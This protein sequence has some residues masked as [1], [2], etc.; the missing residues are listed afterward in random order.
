MEE[1]RT[2]QRDHI[3]ESLHYLMINVLVDSLE[4]EGFVV[5]A[6]HVGGL[7]KR[8]APVGEFVPDIEAWRGEEL[9]LIEVETQ[10]TLASPRT[11]QQLTRFA[12]R[13]GA[14]VYL[15]VP[16]DCIERARKMRE[17]LEINV[18][19]LPCYPFV[20]YIGVPK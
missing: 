7:R 1:E 9:H 5:S 16:F 15:A 13:P 11:G 14:R 12:S 19:I 10:S 6:D 4:N 2:T 8:P 17:C 3:E 20:R 18:R